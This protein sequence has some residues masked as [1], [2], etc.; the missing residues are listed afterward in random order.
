MKQS[1]Y[2][3]RDNLAE[4]FN[5]PF[6]QVNDYTAIRAFT[7]A[8]ESEPHKDDYSLYKLGE[9]DDVSGEIIPKDTPERIFSGLEVKATRETT[10]V[11]RETPHQLVKQAI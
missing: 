2:C 4:I 3:I 8:I 7:T 10:E 1:M 5:K 11:D 9:Y 6:T